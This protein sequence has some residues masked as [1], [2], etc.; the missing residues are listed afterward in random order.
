MAYVKNPYG[1]KMDFDLLN[2][3]MDAALCEEI[4]FD[5]APA[6]EQEFADIYAAKHEKKFGETWYPYTKSPQL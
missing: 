1:E 3:M 4:H 2:G 5:L 6:T